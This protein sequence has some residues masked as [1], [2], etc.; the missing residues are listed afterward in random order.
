MK[1]IKKIIFVLLVVIVL[2][3]YHW[4][5]LDVRTSEVNMVS[6]VDGDTA[7]FIIDGKEEKVRFLAIDAL[8]V[9]EYYGKEA[10]NYVCHA[11]EN[12]ST[13]TLEFEESSYRDKYNRVLAWAFVDGKLLQ[14]EL[15]SRG[16]AQVKYLYDDY[17]YV[18]EL[19]DLQ[20]QAKT[21]KIGIW[22]DKHE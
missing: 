15:I 1:L 4:I 2:V 8:E 19:F 13:I 17:K 5:K 12:A 18:D 16:L 22:S 6:C 7:T 9:N 10:S 21:K 3:L 20:E 14:E 11:L